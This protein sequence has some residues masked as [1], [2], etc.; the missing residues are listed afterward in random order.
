MNV[1]NFLFFQIFRRWK[2]LRRVHLSLRFIWWS[3]FFLFFFVFCCKTPF[4]FYSKQTC[5]SSNSV[6]PTA[7]FLKLYSFWS[8]QGLNYS[9]QSVVTLFFCSGAPN[10]K[11]LL[12]EVQWEVEHACVY[13]CGWFTCA[14]AHTHT[15]KHIHL[16]SW[17]GR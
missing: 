11:N 10:Q 17:W 4:F 5:T 15:H 16:P 9:A 6:K 8:K 2:W 1:R 13:I 7:S 14:R 3:N 12:G